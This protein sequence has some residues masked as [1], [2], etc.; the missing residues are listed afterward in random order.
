MR[1][2][3]FL[4]ELAVMEYI[5]TP[6]KSSSIGLAALM[7]AMGRIDPSDLSD[8][9]KNA[10]VHKVYRVAGVDPDDVEVT[11]CLAR[12]RSMKYEDRVIQE[13]QEGDDVGVEVEAEADAEAEEVEVAVATATTAKPSPQQKPE[14]AEATAATPTSIRTTSP[15]GVADADADFPTN[16]PAPSK[17]AAKNPGK[18]WEDTSSMVISPITKPSSN[19]DEEGPS[20]TVLSTASFAS[21][22][23]TTEKIWIVS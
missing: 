21:G 4:A 2:T 5:F 15:A 6:L 14:A 18:E 7:T 1:V 22:K 16:I 9:A 10:F 12:F 19:D 17:G 13:L 11:M 8:E 3:Q 20:R 23:M